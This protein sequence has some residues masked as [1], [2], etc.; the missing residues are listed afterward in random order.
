VSHP[1]P[2][3]TADRLERALDASSRFVAARGAKGWVMR[4]VAY[5]ACQYCEAVIGLLEG[6]LAEYRAGTLILPAMA[7]DSPASAA[8]HVTAKPLTAARRD[9]RPAARGTRAP[10]ANDP[11]A[12]DPS[13]VDPGGVDPRA[14]PANAS[15]RNAAAPR[16][17]HFSVVP[18]RLPIRRPGQGPRGVAGYP[19]AVP[20]A[21]AQKIGCWRLA[22]THA[23]FVALSK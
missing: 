20:R 9:R 2:L 19:S 23:H 22:L 8:N 7:D 4:I 6:L 12:V 13:A 1:V 17:M 15:E 3:H 11:S 10:C 5:F 18:R 21:A 16:C 14:V